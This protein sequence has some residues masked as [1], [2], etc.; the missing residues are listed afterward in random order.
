[1]LNYTELEEEL[2]RNAPDLYYSKEILGKNVPDTE[3]DESGNWKV[4]LTCPVHT[5]PHL[6]D[7]PVYGGTCEHRDV[8]LTPCF[9]TCI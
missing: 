6:L 7:K 3:K 9:R 1:M 4:P 2:R 5:E 8:I